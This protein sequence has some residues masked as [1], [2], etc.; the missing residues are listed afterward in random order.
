MFFGLSLWGLVGFYTD[1]V[2][3]RKGWEL[4]TVIIPVLGAAMGPVMSCS[5]SLFS[6]LV[7]PGMEAEF[8]SFYQLT[9]RGSSFV[10]PLLFAWLV[11]STGTGRG[12]FVFT[13]LACLFGIVGLAYLDVDKARQDAAVFSAECADQARRTREADDEWVL[14]DDGLGTE[15]IV[16]ETFLTDEECNGSCTSG[17]TSTTVPDVAVRRRDRGASA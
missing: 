5:R 8:F 16:R 12:I 4:Y 11:Q 9:D 6:T 1:Q 13:A 3:F 15:R 17:R 2:G 14:L 7:P 10:G